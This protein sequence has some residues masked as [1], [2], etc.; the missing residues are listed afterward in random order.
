MKII[1]CVKQVPDTN[2]V[3]IDPIKGTL[4]R[5]GVPSILNPDDANALE[6]ALILKDKYDDVHVTVLTMGPPQ[7]D[8]MLR[9]CLAMGADDAIHLSGREFAGGDTWATSNAIAAAIDKVVGEYD[10][11]FAGRQAIDGDTAQVGPQIAERLGIAQVTYV[12]KVDVNGNEL[13]IER[14]LEDGYEVIKAQTPI[15]LTAIKETNT[16]RYMYVKG[17]YDAYKEKEVKVCSFADLGIEQDEVGL[18][19]SPTRVRRSFVPTPKGKGVML[20][21]TAKEMAEKVAIS[22]KQKHL[23]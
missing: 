1:V 12:Q 9:E 13:T 7:A 2:E 5:E 17:I 19:A 3:R 23:I 16:P 15:L 6:E 21:G 22:L 18:K 8:E 20:E 11:I 4:I 14:Q 10:I